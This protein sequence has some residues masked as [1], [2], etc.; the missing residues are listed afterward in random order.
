MRS[1]PARSE[2]PAGMSLQIVFVGHQVF[3]YCCF[4]ALG[5]GVEYP[6]PVRLFEVNNLL[7]NIFAF[8]IGNDPQQFKGHCFRRLSGICHL[9]NSVLASWRDLGPRLSLG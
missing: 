6:L 8:S 7:A 9:L 5:V 2:R 4:E 3:S 1:R